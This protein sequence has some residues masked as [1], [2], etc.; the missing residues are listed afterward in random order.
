LW[1]FEQGQELNKDELTVVQQIRA[2]RPR[3]SVADAY[4]F[5][6]AASRAWTLL[7]GDGELRSLAQERT[8]PF[9]GVL[10]V[11]DQIF[12]AKACAPAKLVVGLEAIAGHQR[13]RL[14]RN[15]IQICLSRYR[16]A[17]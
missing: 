1:R 4:A 11:L 14:P 10:W 17:S 3:L 8:M 9:H 16:K 13:C 12:E 5:S 2:S 6:L 7:T 15:E